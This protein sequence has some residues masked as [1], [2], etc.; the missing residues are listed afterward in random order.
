M[1][2]LLLLILL[3]LLAYIHAVSIRVPVGSL[4]DVNTA[5][6]YAAD[7]D[8]VVMEPGHWTNCSTAIIISKNITISAAGAVVDCMS[9]GVALSTADGCTTAAV[10]FLTISNAIT[11]VLHTS[12]CV[13][14]LINVTVMHSQ[15]VGVNVTGPGA[16]LMAVDC[17]FVHNRGGGVSVEE[18]ALFTANS[19]VISNN[20]KHGNGAGLSVMYNGTS[21]LL[22]SCMLEN[23]TGPA[24]EYLYYYGGAVAADLSSRV[25]IRDSVMSYN[26]AINGGAVAVLEGSTVLMFSCSII[27]NVAIGNNDTYAGCGGAVFVEYTSLLESRDCILYNNIA[28]HG[29]AVYVV[30]NQLGGYPYVYDTR[31]V[32]VVSRCNFTNNTANYSGGMCNMLS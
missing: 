3:S 22:Q 14:T 32:V 25:E 31:T 10:Q 30:Y 15:S 9:S 24:T 26:K 7:G 17:R 5:L 18:G 29:G 20:K 16:V 8:D 1:R 2:R 23:N 6:G 19:T 11:G 13:L 4:A 12:S 21:A 27:G 28:D